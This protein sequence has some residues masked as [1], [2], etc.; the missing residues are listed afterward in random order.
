MA[1]KYTESK[2]FQVSNLPLSAL[3]I[4]SKPTAYMFDFHGI[5][6]YITRRMAVFQATETLETEM[7]E[8][9]T[10]RGLTRPIYS[11]IGEYKRY[12]L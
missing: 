9:L 12:V 6:T 10:C 4:T 1:K 8:V 3:I 2:R 5:Y 11:G 7:Y